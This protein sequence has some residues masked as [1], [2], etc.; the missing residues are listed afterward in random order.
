MRKL[1]VAI[2]MLAFTMDANAGIFGRRQQQVQ[3]SQGCANGKCGVAQATTT[4]TTSSFQYQ[5]QSTPAPV[6]RKLT[7][8]KEEMPAQL[9]ING[10]TYFRH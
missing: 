2:C 6:T 10:V 3:Q 8:L 9:T 1:L 5:L 7:T 4:T